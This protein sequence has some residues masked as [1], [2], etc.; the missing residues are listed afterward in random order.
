[1][2]RSKVA[3]KVRVFIKLRSFR[4]RYTYNGNHS[5]LSLCVAYTLD[6]EEVDEDLSE[7]NE[8]QKMNESFSSPTNAIHGKEIPFVVLQIYAILYSI[9]CY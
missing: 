9:F 3:L 5:D 4:A 8:T 2:R 6:G 1:M 7:T